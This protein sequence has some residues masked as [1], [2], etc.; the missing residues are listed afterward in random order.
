MGVGLAAVGAL[1]LATVSVI[2]SRVIRAGDPRQVILYIAATAAI[3]FLATTL[4]RG[5][6]LLPNTTWAW[7]GFV[8][9][10]IFF[11]AAV[12]G[13]FV[14]IQ[15]IGPVRTT[16]FSYIEPVATIAAAFILLE[17]SL[18][19]LQVFGV[20]IV[21]GALIVAGRATQNP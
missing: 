2:S 1:G 19:P 15:L 21:I 20:V 13:Y 12:I 5:E 3:I 4:V 8:T 9:N 14:G 11:A 17:Q 16:L 7:W 10:N 18:A 6:F